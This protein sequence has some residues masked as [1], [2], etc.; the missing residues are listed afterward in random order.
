MFL[1]PPPNKTVKTLLV[2]FVL[3]G[4]GMSFQLLNPSLKFFG[5]SLLNKHCLDQRVRRIRLRLDLLADITLDL[6]IA[7]ASLLRR[8]PQAGKQTIDKL[9]FLILHLSI[10]LAASNARPKLAI[11]LILIPRA[12]V[13]PYEVFVSPVVI[14]V[15]RM[16]SL[17]KRATAAMAVR[18]WRE[19]ARLIRQVLRMSVHRRSQPRPYRPVQPRFAP[20]GQQ[21]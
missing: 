2:L 19:F 13:Q 1:L 6:F 18:S 4:A 9:L 12:K 7:C 10:A 16:E 14:A 17:S 15:V 8:L 3:G 20:I 21:Y 11:V 5:R